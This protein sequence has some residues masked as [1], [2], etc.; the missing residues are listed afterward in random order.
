MK[1]LRVQTSKKEDDYQ[2]PNE[3]LDY[4]IPFINKDWI[5]WEC[6][7]GKGNILNYLKEKGF[8]IIGTDKETNFLTNE[9]HCDV[10]ITNPPYSL[11]D[12]F[13][14]RCY[15]LNKPFALLM[16]LTSLE[17]QKRGALYRQ[18]GLQLIIPDKRINFEHAKGIN[19]GAWFQ[20]AWFCWGFKLQNDL[21]FISSKTM[22]NAYNTLIAPK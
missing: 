22:K 10:I 20:T 7:C 8:D 12:E 15:R 5:I 19:S 4:L 14:D 9:I 3:A 18:F 11:K 6:A 13:I 2:T 16:P 1:K 21:M 17:G